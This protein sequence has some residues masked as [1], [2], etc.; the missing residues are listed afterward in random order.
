MS[1]HS[2]AGCI[3][4]EIELYGVLSSDDVQEFF[5]LSAKLFYPGTKVSSTWLSLHGRKIG[6]EYIGLLRKMECHDLGINGLGFVAREM[7]DVRKGAFAA[8][9]AFS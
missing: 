5:C 8:V 3:I 1:Q 6:N 7:E 4:W 2:V 9:L